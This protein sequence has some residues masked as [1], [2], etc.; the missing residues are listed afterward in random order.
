[1]SSDRLS[2]LLL[3]T[4]DNPELPEGCLGVFIVR[5]NICSLYLWAQLFMFF[6]QVLGSVCNIY[7]PILQ[8]IAFRD[9]I[10]F[11]FIG[12]ELCFC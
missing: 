8:C 9:Q 11:F 12:A 2:L 7:I 5:G 1:M 10:A 4:P 6:L 3:N